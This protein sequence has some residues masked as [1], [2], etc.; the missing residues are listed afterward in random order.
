MEDLKQDKKFLE[1]EKIR[2]DIDDVDWSKMTYEE[3]EALDEPYWESVANIYKYAQTIKGSNIVTIEP[4]S[5]YSHKLLVTPSN[6]EVVAKYLLSLPS[7]VE[8]EVK[9]YTEKHNKWLNDYQR[10]SDES[11]FMKEIKP[12]KS[13]KVIALLK[14]ESERPNFDEQNITEEEFEEADE[15]FTMNE[16]LIL[17]Q[18]SPSELMSYS[19]SLIYLDNDYHF[20][21]GFKW[22]REDRDF[23][24]EVRFKHL[25]KY[26]EFSELEKLDYYHRR[27]RVIYKIYRNKIATNEY[28]LKLSK[29][30]KTQ[31]Q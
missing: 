7:F 21:E 14:K 13:D 24:T 9:I 20:A 26:N 22:G 12:I 1:L 25:S 3:R 4:D 6:V 28:M 17:S 15:L 8:I 27:I 18:L 19:M 23:Y 30:L 11:I 2:F 16:G 5:D 31:N 10:E 29:E